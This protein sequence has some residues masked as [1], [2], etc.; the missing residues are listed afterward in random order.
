LSDEKAPEV[1]PT[2]VLK[3]SVVADAEAEVEVE[4]EALPEFDSP[5]GE[6]HSPING[7]W[8]KGSRRQQRAEMRAQNKAGK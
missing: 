5:H 6:L 1:E 8:S 4:P 3:D 2:A 7:K